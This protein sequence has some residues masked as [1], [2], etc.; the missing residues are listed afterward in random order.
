MQT[1]RVDLYWLCDYE[2]WSHWLWNDTTN[3]DF[4]TW[5]MGG[6]L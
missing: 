5:C 6:E 4:Q 3:S 2:Y 1:N